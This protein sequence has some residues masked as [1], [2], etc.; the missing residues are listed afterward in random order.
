MKGL[1][2]PNNNFNN[3]VGGKNVN[4]KFMF[5]NSLIP[6]PSSSD[7]KT[8]SSLK[9]VEVPVPQPKVKILKNKEKLIE[10]APINNPFIEK[11]A[12]SLTINDKTLI[13]ELEVGKLVWDEQIDT[14]EIASGI[15]KLNNLTEEQKNKF[16]D[17]LDGAENHPIY[18]LNLSKDTVA[19]YICSH[20]YELSK[21]IGENEFIGFF[22]SIGFHITKILDIDYNGQPAARYMLLNPIIVPKNAVTFVPLSDRTHLS[23]LSCRDT[24]I[25][26]INQCILGRPH[27]LVFEP[28]LVEQI[29]EKMDEILDTNDK[30]YKE[31][32]MQIIEKWKNMI[33]SGKNADTT[34]NT[35]D[36]VKKTV[37]EYLPWMK[38]K[39]TDLLDVKDEILIEQNKGKEHS[40]LENLI[41]KKEE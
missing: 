16:L 4:A 9:Y 10:L 40:S 36:E 24:A 20:F 32:Q 39:A 29:Q 14:T 6:K 3:N 13:E 34:A 17:F 23:M 30:E 18:Y 1:P 12:V 8:P 28:Y 22:S 37:R 5:K 7:T 21:T 35:W 27:L 2:P 19:L 33:I 38:K 15:N 31:S 25:F 11:P 26:F 41:N